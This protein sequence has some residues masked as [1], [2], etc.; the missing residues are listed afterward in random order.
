MISQPAPSPNI[1]SSHKI[2]I[3][4]LISILSRFVLANADARIEVTSSGISKIPVLPAGNAASSVPENKIP[5]LAVYSPVPPASIHVSSPSSY[6]LI[7]YYTN[8]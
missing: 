6:I 1:P 8:K 5:S 3:Q 4:F 2:E 7:D